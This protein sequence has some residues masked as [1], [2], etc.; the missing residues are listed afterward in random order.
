MREPALP[1]TETNALFLMRI[2]A[3]AMISGVLAFGL[4]A[5]IVKKDQPD[6]DPVLSYAALVMALVCLGTRLVVPDMVARSQIKGLASDESD[7]I[8]RELL[9]GAFRTR[10]IV[11]LALCE[12]PAFFNLIAWWLEG[13]TLA[14]AT[15]GFLLLVMASSIPTRGRLEAWI[16][17]N[18]S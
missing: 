10:L 14:I 8:A 6:A 7:G 9:I 2:I 5:S 12:G 3:G 4:I 15:V 13:Q 1:T 16:V 11:G 18:R 17:Q